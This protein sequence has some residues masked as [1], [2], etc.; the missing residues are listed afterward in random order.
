MSNPFWLEE[1]L[2]PDDPDGWGSWPRCVAVIPDTWRSL[3]R[4]GGA[5][6]EQRLAVA[7]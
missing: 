7:S 3:C 2:G 1:T 5:V 4:P 6:E